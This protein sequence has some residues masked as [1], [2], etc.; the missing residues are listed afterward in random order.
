MLEIGQLAKDQVYM[1]TLG[2]KR[3][4][5]VLET[6]S[7][8]IEEITQTGRPPEV[9]TYRSATVLVTSPMFP[10]QNHVTEEEAANNEIH[11]RRVKANTGDDIWTEVWIDFQ[12]PKMP[13][14]N[15]KEHPKTW[16]RCIRVHDVIGRH[17]MNEGD[18]KGGSIRNQVVDGIMIPSDDVHKLMFEAVDLDEMTQAEKAKELEKKDIIEEYKRQVKAEEREARKGDPAQCKQWGP[19]TVLKLQLKLCG[20]EPPE[21]PSDGSSW[22][23]AARHVLKTYLNTLGVNPW[24]IMALDGD[25]FHQMLQDARKRAM[26]RA[27]EPEA[28]AV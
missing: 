15:P 26:K 21:K 7:I 14:D 13:V 17:G 16:E 20:L 4:G 22:N 18:G 3:I 28:I 11:R 27:P 19:N 5:K 8:E 12:R 2:P 24:D 9:K 6:G 23:V 1:M 25:E 10:I